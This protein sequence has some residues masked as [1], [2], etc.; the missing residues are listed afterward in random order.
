MEN[1]EDL[2]DTDKKIVLNLGAGRV[3]LE[4][5]TD[6]FNGWKEIKVDIKDVEPDIVSDLVDLKGIPDQ[7]ADAIWACHVVEHMF[8]HDLPSVFNSMMRVLK[9]DGF[10]IIRVPDLAS[11][12]HLIPDKLLE[13]IYSTDSGIDVTPL[14]MLYSYRGFFDSTNEK[15]DYNHAMC[16]KTGFTPK[17]IS[18]ILDFLN[19]K[20]FVSSIGYE[21]HCV[22]YKDAIPDFITDKS[23]SY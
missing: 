12:A 22:I 8:W 10:G 4:Q 19:I 23:K 9:D 2:F 21:I 1:I 14:D 17:S 20:G 5:H 15:K 7:C 18:Q 3:A 6:Y 11:I 13:P 16:H